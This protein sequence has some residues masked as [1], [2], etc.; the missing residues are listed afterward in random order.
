MSQSFR[1]ELGV[2]A[3]D[4]ITGFEGTVASRTQHITGCDTYSLHPPLRPDGRLEDGRIFD[5]QRIEVLNAVP[6]TLPASTS[7]EPKPGADNTAR[8]YK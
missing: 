4:V 1:I 5:D 3:R 7:P 8:P 6:V 2:K